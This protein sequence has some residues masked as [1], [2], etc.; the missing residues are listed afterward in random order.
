MTLHDGVR[1]MSVTSVDTM[2]TNHLTP[3]RIA[4]TGPVL[5]GCGLGFGTA[6]V[7]EPDEVSAVRGRYGWEGGYG[8]IWFN[9]PSEDLV[10][11]ALTQTADFNW[12]GGAAEFSKLACAR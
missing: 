2:T 4:G 12:N 3:P 9:D 10:A 8:T 6:V 5:A 1:L 7:T 11:I